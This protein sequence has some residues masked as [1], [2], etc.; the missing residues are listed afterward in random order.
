[1]PSFLPAEVAEKL[2]IE[3]IEAILLYFPELNK[4]SFLKI[5]Q[6]CTE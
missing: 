5:L 1:M 4:I 6:K 3:L 2:H